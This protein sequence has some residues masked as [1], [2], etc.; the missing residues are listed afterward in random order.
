MNKS[1]PAS[2][3][4]NKAPRHVKAAPRKA[5]KENPVLVVRPRQIRSISSRKPFFLL[6][7]SCLLWSGDINHVLA[8]LP[9]QPLFDFVVTSPP[10]NLG[11][12]YEKLLCPT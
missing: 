9:E 10:Y 2:A 11:K 6:N 8:V 5:K 12:D 4:K 1:R 3:G 7:T